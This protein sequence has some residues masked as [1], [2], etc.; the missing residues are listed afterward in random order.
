MIKKKIQFKVW[1]Q[2]R[3]A[4]K[5][6]LAIKDFFTNEY[7]ISPEFLVP[8][9]H[10]TIYHSRRPMTD[11]EEVNKSC[12]VSIDTLDTRFMVLAPG[13]ENPRPT[14]I[15]AENKVGI[16]I[17]KSSK[18]RDKILE[19]RQEFFLHETPKI[20][21]LRKPS[22]KTRSAF[23]AKNFQPHITLLN[24]G[25]GIQTDLTEVGNNFRD[26]VHEIHFDRFII[27]KRRY[28]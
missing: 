11:I 13:G 12:L 26:S 7:N 9:L 4:R 8:N 27:R 23:G 16:R 5:S 28:F 6:E 19:Y 25:S 1:A 17:H 20:L 22:S 10:L 2:F 21:G 15:P 14:L 3:V 24:L 18:F